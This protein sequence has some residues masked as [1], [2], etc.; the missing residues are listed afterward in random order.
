MAGI[1]PDFRITLADGTEYEVV[2]RFKDARAWEQYCSREGV[3]VTG[4]PFTMGVFFAWREARK[5]GLSVD[6]D[7]DDFA[8][9]V[10]NL[11]RFEAEKPVPTRPAP[12][13]G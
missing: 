3:E 13:A 4:S 12:G 1:F 7:L 10:A 5:R 11:D 2:T 6:E 9:R 8:D